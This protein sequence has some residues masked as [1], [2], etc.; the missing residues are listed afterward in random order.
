MEN[1]NQKISTKKIKIHEWKLF[2]KYFVELFYSIS[3]F[4]I[5]SWKNYWNQRVEFTKERIK[6]TLFIVW[7]DWIQQPEAKAQKSSKPKRRFFPHIKKKLYIS[8]HHHKMNWGRH[9]DQRKRDEKIMIHLFSS[10]SSLHNFWRYFSTAQRMI[11]D[12]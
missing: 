2:K 6:I 1:L 12:L 3:L 5:H 7:L 11:I 4:P 10:S 9:S 8:Y